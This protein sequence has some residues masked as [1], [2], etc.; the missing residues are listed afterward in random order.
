MQV[1]REKAGTAE[2]QNSMFSRLAGRV[3]KYLAT[4]FFGSACGWVIKLGLERLVAGYIFLT[5]PPSHP[6]VKMSYVNK[7]MENYHIGLY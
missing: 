2:D 5:I 7:D 3:S 1:E 6:V 4:H